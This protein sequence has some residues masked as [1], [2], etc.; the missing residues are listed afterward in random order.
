MQQFWCTKIGVQNWCKKIKKESRSIVYAR[1][2]FP[3]KTAGFLRQ[4]F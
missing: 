3:D 4:K 1:I 2:I